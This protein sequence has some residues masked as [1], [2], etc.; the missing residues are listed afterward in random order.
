M[1]TKG[2]HS[3]IHSKCKLIQQCN[4]P[5]HTEWDRY[6][7]EVKLLVVFQCQTKSKGRYKFHL[8]IKIKLSSSDQWTS[9]T[10][11]MHQLSTKEVCQASQ[12]QW[13]I[14]LKVSRR[15]L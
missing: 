3:K 4:K 10:L 7:K 2:P 15:P 13:L 12:V 6:L 8:V 11:R 14:L 1:T 5:S 9:I